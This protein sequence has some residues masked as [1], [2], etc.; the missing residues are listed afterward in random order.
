MDL[1]QFADIIGATVEISGCLNGGNVYINAHLKK[2]FEHLVVEDGR[3]RSYP[4]GRSEEPDV[5][6]ALESLARNIAGRTIVFGD[7]PYQVPKDIRGLTVQC[8]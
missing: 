3:T 4:F 6:E 7:T 5:E 1:L 8:Q 2:G